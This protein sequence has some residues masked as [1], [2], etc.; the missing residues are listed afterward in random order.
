[1]ILITGATGNIGTELVKRLVN[2][3]I[4]IR[5]ITRDE[6]KI[7]HLGPEVE[8]VIGDRHEPSVVQRALQGVEK[9]FVL[10]GPFD[11]DHEADRLLMNKAKNA[12]VRQ[13]VL[14]SS[15]TVHVA[16]KNSIGVF[17]REKEIARGKV[18]R[19]MDFFA[20]RRVHVEW[21]AMGHQYP[22]SISKDHN[23]G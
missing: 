2:R 8:R 22:R 23:L 18:R 14:I 7:V 1:M 4:P 16:E 12:C 13:I 17:H 10:S 20:T 6:K 11:I 9:V 3:R 5:V 21:F 15:S 19:P